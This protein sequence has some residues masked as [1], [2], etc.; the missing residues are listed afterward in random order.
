MKKVFYCIALYGLLLYGCGAE[1]PV[2]IEKVNGEALYVCDYFKTSDSTVVLKLGDILES[3]EIVKLDSDTSATIGGGTVY[4]SDNYMMIPAG[5]RQPVKLFDRKG[6]YLRNIGKVG[7]GPGEYISLYDMQI[8]EKNKRIFLMPWQTR[9]L[10]E[11]NMEGDFVKPIPMMG[12]A[13]KA[14]FSVDG[15]RLTVLALP[16]KGLKW[17]AFQQTLDGKLLDS[18]PVGQFEINERNPYNNELYGSRDNHYVH[19]FRSMGKIQDTLYHYVPGKSGL[20]PKFT[21]DFGNTVP[22]IHEYR[23]FGDYFYFETSVTK[24]IDE[25][26]FTYVTEKSILVNKKTRDATRFKLVNDLLGGYETEVWRFSNG[27]YVENLDPLKLK[28]KLE[29]VLDK[30]GLDKAMEK[31]ITDLVNSI[32]END[33]NYIIYGK[34]K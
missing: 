5:Y 25:S 31:K 33:N 26:S 32:D 24:P 7:R 19:I 23:E 9:Y 8:D 29:K 34:L 18:V 4:F 21:V 12:G 6:N 15:D 20:I 17:V 13:P 10:Y 14:K 27:Y 28:D 1:K 2:R 30:G 22:P 16:F 11:F 3:L